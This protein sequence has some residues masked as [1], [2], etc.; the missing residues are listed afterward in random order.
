M[1]NVSSC[2]SFLDAGGKGLVGRGVD[3]AQPVK[4]FQLVIPSTAA[5]TLAAV[6]ANLVDTVQQV[7]ADLRVTRGGQVDAAIAEIG[8]AS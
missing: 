5:D 4:D 7:L 6:M 2:A 8:R 1:R 3:Q